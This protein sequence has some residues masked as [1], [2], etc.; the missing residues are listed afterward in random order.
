MLASWM[1]YNAMARRN[2]R[3][4]VHIETEEELGP[5]T[6]GQSGDNQ[7]LSNVAQADSE[8]VDELAEEGQF[9]EASLISGIED[10]PDADVAEVTTRQVPEDDV[11]LEYQN[12]DKD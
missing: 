6:G 7:G 1:E 5:D 10:A 11:P 4:E 9:Y 3:D 8:S 2:T 12:Q